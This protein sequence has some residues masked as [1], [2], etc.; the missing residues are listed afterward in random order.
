MV[1]FR[2]LKP[3]TD[4]AVELFANREAIEAI[5]L[6]PYEKYVEQFAGAVTALL[7]I[8]PTVDSVDALLTEEDETRFIQAFRELIRIQ[9]VLGCFTEFSYDDL[10]MDAQRFEEYKSKYLDLYDKVRTNRQKEKNLDP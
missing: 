6:Q 9:N 5:I 10:A 4:Q 3:A 2:N 8:A 1:C 7:T